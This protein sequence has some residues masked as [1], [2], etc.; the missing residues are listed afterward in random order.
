MLTSQS[1]E[2]NVGIPFTV[3]PIVACLSSVIIEVNNFYFCNYI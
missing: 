3:I 1:S 2:E